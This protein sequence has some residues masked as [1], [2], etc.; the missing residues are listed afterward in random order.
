MGDELTIFLLGF[1]ALLLFFGLILVCVRYFCPEQDRF[2]REIARKRKILRMYKNL[3][4]RCHDEVNDDAWDLAF[5][6]V[7]YDSKKI[8]DQE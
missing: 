4:S 6:T 8:K 3:V 7:A 2:E 5:P 1:L